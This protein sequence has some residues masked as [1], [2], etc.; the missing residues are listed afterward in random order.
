M[1]GDKIGEMSGKITSQRVLSIA[2]GRL[3]METVDSG[4]RDAAWRTG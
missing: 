2:E 3:K 1:L 4:K